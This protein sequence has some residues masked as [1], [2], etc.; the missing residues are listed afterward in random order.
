MSTYGEGKF[1]G[2]HGGARWGRHNNRVLQVPVPAVQWYGACAAHDLHRDVVVLD[3]AGHVPD[4]DI[5]DNVLLLAPQVTALDG[6]KGAS[7]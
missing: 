3:L 2:W 7:L 4:G 1:N 6:D 5:L